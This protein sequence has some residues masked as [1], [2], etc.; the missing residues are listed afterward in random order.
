VLAFTYPQQPAPGHLFIAW[1]AALQMKLRL[2]SRAPVLAAVR[3][4]WRRGK[5]CPRL[6][7]QSITALLPSAGR[8]AAAAGDRA[9]RDYERAH[10]VWRAEGIDPRACW[11]GLRLQARTATSSWG[12]DPLLF[13]EGG[14]VRGPARPRKSAFHPVPEERLVGFA[15]NREETP[16]TA[17]PPVVPSFTAPSSSTRA[18]VVTT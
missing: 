8:S 2:K 14:V 9:G 5:A 18:G 12:E 3:E 7:E 1:M 15:Q 10:A 6:M 4:A 13:E 11:P 16:A 17:W